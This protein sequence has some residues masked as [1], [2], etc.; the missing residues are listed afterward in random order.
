MAWHTWWS[1]TED[2]IRRL[3]AVIRAVAT[4]VKDMHAGSSSEEDASHA[5]D[6]ADSAD[7]DSAEWRGGDGADPPAQP[8]QPRS[9]E[10]RG[11]E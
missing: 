1:G 3:T 8:G 4:E 9:P 5:T 10:T 6:G 11:S 2:K 7:G